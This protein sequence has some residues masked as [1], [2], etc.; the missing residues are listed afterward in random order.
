MSSVFLWTSAAAFAALILHSA[1]AVRKYGLSRAL[2]KSLARKGSFTSLMD[3]RRWWAAI[4]H[5]YAIVGEAQAKHRTTETGSEEHQQAQQRK[6]QADMY[7]WHGWFWE[8]TGDINQQRTPGPT[9]HDTEAADLDGK[10]LPLI[11]E[12]KEKNKIISMEEFQTRAHEHNWMILDGF[13][14]DVSKWLERHPG[15]RTVLRKRVGSDITDEFRRLRHSKRAT[16][17]AAAL[18]VGRSE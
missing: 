13:V 12:T 18:V 3:P 15:G 5:W 6:I 16:S 14:V 2:A 11:P 10:D 1:W 9:L 8:M 7:D 4:F 17:V